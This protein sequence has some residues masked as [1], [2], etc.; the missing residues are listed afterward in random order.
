MRIQQD[1]RTRVEHRS[2]VHPY[3]IVVVF[4]PGS[5]VWAEIRHECG[6]LIDSLDTVPQARKRLAELLVE[7]VRD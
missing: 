2:R 7:T 3:Q 6:N 4:V 5:P 1:M